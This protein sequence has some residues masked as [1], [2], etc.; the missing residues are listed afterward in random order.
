MTL[1]V[2]RTSYALGAEI[3]GIDLRQPLGDDTFHEV[4]QALLEH[5]VLLFRN[6]LLN[7]EQHI[8]FT[9]RFGEIETNPDAGPQFVHPKYREV[10]LG[11][12]P[13]TKGTPT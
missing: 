3:I 5:S 2:R 7:Q 8:A 11:F 10:F 13:N 1:E 12:N 6:Q 9:R 4:H